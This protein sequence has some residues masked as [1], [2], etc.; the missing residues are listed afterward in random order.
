MIGHSIGAVSYLIGLV[1]NIAAA[2]CVDQDANKRGN[3]AAI[4]WAIGTFF[5]C[6]I[7]PIIYLITR[8]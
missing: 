3:S 6:P 8:K 2:F 5:C 1:I 7:V 4:G